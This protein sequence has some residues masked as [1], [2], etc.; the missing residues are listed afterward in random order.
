MLKLAVFTDE[1]S[2][3]PEKAVKLALEF[4]LQGVEIRSV[5]DTQPQDL[6][7]S[8]IT[9][10]NRLLQA[11]DLKAAAIASPFLKCNLGDE[12][13][14]RQH[15]DILRRCIALGKSLGTNIIRGFTCWKTEDTPEV[16][17]EVERLYHKVIPILEAEKAILAIENEHDTTAGTAASVALFLG[18]F[19]HSL[20]RAVWDPANEVFAEGG[21]APYPNAYQRIKPYVAHVHVKDALRDDAGQPHVAIVGKGSIDWRGQLKAL[22][23]DGYGGWISLET[24]SR[25]IQL[26]EGTDASRVE[27]EASRLCLTALTGMLPAK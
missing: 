7:A 13:A 19:N 3:D 20:L 26:P 12:E 24:H 5:W 15:F 11:H 6:S 10:L 23:E 25:M 17:A 21:E 14:Y 8:Q 27:E 22:A 16:W 9:E 18:K 2:Q 4:G 1:V